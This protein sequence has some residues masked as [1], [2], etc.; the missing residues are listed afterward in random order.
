MGVLMQP[1]KQANI[2]V[3]L[4]M[5]ANQIPLEYSVVY[6]EPSQLRSPLGP[7]LALHRMKLL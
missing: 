6:L 5:I 3:L 1:S 7:Q 2:V 4:I